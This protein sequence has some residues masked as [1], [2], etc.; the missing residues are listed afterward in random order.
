M[1]WGG[2]QHFC[3]GKHWKVK[4]IDFNEKV[5]RETWPTFT[6]GTT[7]LCPALVKESTGRVEDDAAKF[8]GLTIIQV[9]KIFQN[10]FYPV[11]ADRVTPSMVVA[12]IWDVLSS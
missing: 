4:V 12:R 11:D 3:T 10:S 8:F 2:R 6:H 1:R 9:Q 5:G 7:I